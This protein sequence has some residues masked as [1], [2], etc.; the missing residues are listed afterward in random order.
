MT[1]YLDYAKAEVCDRNKILEQYT[2]DSAY[3]MLKGT[4]LLFCV[5]GTYIKLESL[6][7]AAPFC[8]KDIVSQFVF[9]IRNCLLPKKITFRWKRIKY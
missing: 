3:K 5:E 4:P 6:I 2:T 1:I 9:C 7:D 8:Y